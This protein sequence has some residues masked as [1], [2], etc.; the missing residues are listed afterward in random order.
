MVSTTT[1]PRATWRGESAPR[2]VLQIAMV[3][4]LLDLIHRRL[5][6]L[7][8]KIEMTAHG[9]LVRSWP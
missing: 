2:R 9:P 8:L 4:L 5:D 3:L 1:D 7:V 6:S